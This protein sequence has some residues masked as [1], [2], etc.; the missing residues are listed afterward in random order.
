VPRLRIIGDV[1]I[2]SN[3]IEGYRPSMVAA[4]K[5]VPIRN[6]A[7]ADRYRNFLNVMAVLLFLFH[8]LSRVCENFGGSCEIFVCRILE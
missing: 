1:L 7:W 4:K 8:G 2:V 3:L 6:Y 5:N